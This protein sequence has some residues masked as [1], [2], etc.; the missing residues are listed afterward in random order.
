VPTLDD[1]LMAPTNYNHFDGYAQG[2]ST[3]DKN[4]NPANMCPD[5][6]EVVGT[7]ARRF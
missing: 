2:P 7:T 4:I 5:W 1:A 6:I 3:P